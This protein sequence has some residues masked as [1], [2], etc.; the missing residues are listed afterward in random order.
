MTRLLF[1]DDA[2]LK[3]CLAT[4]TNVTEKG[5]QFD[6]TIFY[7]T[8]GGQAGDTGFMTINGVEFVVSSTIYDEN[9]H[10]TH[11]VDGEHG[12]KTGDDVVLKLD[13]GVRYNKMRM[14]TGLHLLSVV[15]AF[16]VTGGSIGA[17]EGRLDFDIPENTMTKEEISEKLNALIS[18]NAT[19][20]D[21]YITD[22]ELEA[23]PQMVKTMSV[24]PPMGTGK[25]RLVNIEGL[26]LQPCGG[27]HVKN[28]SEIGTLTITAIEKKGK[29]N[30]RVRVGFV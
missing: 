10:L 14:H 1:R 17:N 26:D 2:Y 30:R 12:L 29:Q 24:K 23:N 21:Q 7:A 25:V 6:Q 22:A 13:W 16:P 28:T 27:T 5:V 3:T 11:V 20:S 18:K 9:K 19:V 4:V 15:L 8:S